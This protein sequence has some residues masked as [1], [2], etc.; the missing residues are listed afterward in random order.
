VSHLDGDPTL[1]DLMAALA[2][3]KY[4]VIQM[5]PT[6]RWDQRVPEDL[7]AHLLWLRDLENEDKVF[8][9]GPLDWDTWD[10]TGMC[11]IR[12]GSREEA[13]VIAKTEPFQEMGYR[14]NTVREW[15]V[16]EGSVT[17][18]LKLFTDR[19]SFR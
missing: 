13:E 10:G 16:N 6:D 1:D 5:K 18:N 19:W 15:R 3:I 2:G 8:L 17:V 14:D 9:S 4:Y 11:V 7:R 12:S